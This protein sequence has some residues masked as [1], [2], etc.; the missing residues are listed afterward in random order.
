MVVFMKKFN[1]YAI[2]FF[3]LISALVISAIILS[4]I[5]MVYINDGVHIENETKATDYKWE[6]NQFKSTMKEGYVWFRMDEYGFNNVYKKDDKIDIL[7][8]GS[9]HMEGG[10]V[11]PKETVGYRLNELLPEMSTYNIGVSGHTIYNCV[12]NLENAVNFYLP[13][14]YVILETG[15]IKFNIQS[16]SDVINGEFKRHPSYDSGLL[17]YVQKHVPIVKAI[18]K[19]LDEWQSYSNVLVKDENFTSK[20]DV[21]FADE[22]YLDTTSAFLEKAIKPVK[23]KNCKLIIFYQPETKINKDGSWKTTT[24]A[25][26]LETFKNL[27]KEKDICFVDMTDKFKNLY[28]TEHILA[29]GFINTAVGTGHLNKYGH[30]L[31]AQ[32]LKDEIQTDNKVVEDLVIK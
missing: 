3:K 10:N 7:L 32:V 8:M 11:Y 2:Y 21:D 30:K 15:T 5:T 14:K 16:M 13:Q 9:S 17:Y 23:A 28:E 18:Y 24:D 1:N 29:H 26:Y 19:Q 4:L 22:E 31:I 27:C 25:R 6:P 20:Q 12:N